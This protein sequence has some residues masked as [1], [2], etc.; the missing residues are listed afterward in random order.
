MKKFQIVVDSSS[1]MLKEHFADENI[2]LNIVPLSI[3]V[4]G[5]DF[6]DEPGL[7]IDVM[8][9]EMHSLKEKSTSSCPPVGAFEEMFNKAENTICITLSSKLSGT[10]NSARLAADMV[11]KNVHVIDSKST[12]GA[13]VLIA[14][15]C[16]ELMK[17]DLSFD[18][19]VKQVEQ[20]SIDTQLLFVLDSFDNLVKNGRISKVSG[21]LGSLLNI[22]PI[23]TANEVGEITL[24]EKKRTTKAALNRLVEMIGETVSNISERNLI[25][26]HCFDLEVATEIKKLICDKYNFISVRI[27]SMK[28]LCSF[29][30]LEKGIIVS[31]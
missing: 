29:Y 21:L 19:I 20:F 8:L 6:I 4:G 9:K 26:A 15:K 25:I 2:L 10:F 7:N 11:D 23:A 31:F 18:D 17:Q 3:H 28:G 30:A 5:K 13:L 27:Q 16:Y 22:K 12:S 24:V 1:D 14:E